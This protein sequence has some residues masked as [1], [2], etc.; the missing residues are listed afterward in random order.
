MISLVDTLCFRQNKMPQT[1]LF[2]HE[3]SSIVIDLQY[4]SQ[5]SSF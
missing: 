2:L 1:A 5:D 3:A 4:Q